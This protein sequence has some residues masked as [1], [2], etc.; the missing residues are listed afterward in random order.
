MRRASCQTCGAKLPAKSKFC[1]ECGTAVASGD[2]VVQEVPPAEDGPTPVQPHVSER[3]YF[4]VPPAGVLLVLAVAGMIGAIA[5]FAT[6]LWPWGLIVL[7]VSLFLV[8]G[9]I[10]ARTAQSRRGGARVSCLRLGLVPGRGREGDGRGTRRR[11]DR[12]RA[13]A[14]RRERARARAQRACTGARRGRVREE[15]DRD[16]G[17]EAADEGD[18][19]RASGEGGP[20][21]EGDDRRAGPDRQG[22]APGPADPGRGRTSSP[23]R[24]PS[25]QPCRSRSRRPTRGNRR[26]RRRSRSRIRPRTRATARSCR[27]S[28][29]RARSSAPNRL[30]PQNPLKSSDFCIR[31]GTFCPVTKDSPMPRRLLLFSLV[32]LIAVMASTTGR[33]ARADRIQSL[34]AKIAERPGPGVAAAVR[35]RLDREPDPHAREPGR[36]RLDEARRARARP[37]APAG[38]G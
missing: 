10:S 13:A 20:D 27:R 5:L 36:R 7:G 38:C 12:A 37:R 26:S 14:A 16:E 31:A 1:P 18:R 30:R 21:G 15:H 9:F 35:H 8:T 4:G 19:R 11:Q 28:R 6:G 25:R 23:T 22:E 29:S 2:T 3:R 33:P 17:A 24:R 32:C 34:Q